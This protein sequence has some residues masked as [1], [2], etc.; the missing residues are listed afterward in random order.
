MNFLKRICSVLLVLIMTAALFVPALAVGNTSEETT[1]NLVVTGYKLTSPTGTVLGKVKKGDIVNAEISLKN[2]GLTT[3]KLLVDKDKLAEGENAKDYLDISK[4]LDSFTGNGSPEV[5]ITSEGSSALEFKLTFKSITYSGFGKTLSYMI[6]YKKLSMPYDK[7]E[8]NCGECTEYQEPTPTNPPEYTP[9]T[10]PEPLLFF[11]AEGTSPDMKSGEERTIKVSV[12]NMGNTTVTNP[13]AE[14]NVS[15]GLMLAG[16]GN[17]LV[18]KN[19]SPG[20]SETVDVKIR[21]LNQIS[22]PTQVLSMDIKFNYFNGNGTSVGSVSGKI[23]IPC[24]AQGKNEIS[25]PTVI[26]TREPIEK[27]I[28]A[29]QTIPVTMSFKNAGKTALLTPVI[30][31]TTSESLM[32][33]DK[34]STLVLGNINPGETKSVTVNVRALKDIGSSNQSLNAEMKFS[35]ETGATTENG[36][37]SDKVMIPANVTQN[38]GS[39]PSS[40]VP[41]IIITE[42]DYG[43]K[44]VDANSNFELK[45]KIKNTSKTLR[46][47]NI[48]M[49]VDGGD[50][51]TIAS[52]TNT[53]YYE[54]IKAG[55]IVDQTV[56]LQALPTAKSGAQS[57]EVNFKYEY[58]DKSTRSST[59]MSEKLSVPV[60]QPDRFELTAPTIPENVNA[61][62][63]ATLSIPY[64]NKGKS[65]VSNVA[66]EI[67]GEVEA[68]VK[69]QNL[70]N[71]ESGKSGNIGFAFT[72]MK[73]GDL[74]LTLKISYEDANQKPQVRE[75]PVTI[76]VLEPVP[77]TDEM[78]G[79]GEPE[80]SS[81]KKVWYIAIPAVLLAGGAAAFFMIKK[82]KQKG[83]D[84]TASY[85]WDE[86]ESEFDS[87]SFEISDN[88]QMSSQRS[89]DRNEV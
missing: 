50:S 30:I 29:G 4:L 85:S 11:S 74:K 88:E 54:S 75:F 57:I 33:A 16:G 18:L 12:K 5:E 68:A 66:A 32:I 1:S 36:S 62:E 44:A 51:F 35:Y 13:I 64:V 83:K 81:G 45:L 80:G 49:A 87:D 72:A 55:G 89:Q 60:S 6:G 31:F 3:K 61:G 79:M 86:D 40:A 19:I 8:I 47:E 37:T 59:T 20:K 78:E 9:E 39:G 70:G 76:K 14:L 43:G 48:V 82:K 15:D 21:A 23:G 84:E 22:S 2:P 73:A 10:I 26:V 17:S 27:P 69:R 53:F 25:A 42:I 52:S 46:T 34:T 7:G 77:P 24:K 71:F 65:E 41:N 28:S 58:V 38:S 67:I 63:E 56:S